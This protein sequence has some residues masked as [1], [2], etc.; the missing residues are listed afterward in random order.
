MSDRP[1]QFHADVDEEGLGLE[2]LPTSPGVYIFSDEHGEIIYIGKAANLRNRVRNYFHRSGDNRFSVQYIRTQCKRIDTILT[3]NE[4]EAFLLENTLIKKHRP[5]YNIRLRDDK[6]Y[7]SVAIDPTAEWPRA[8]VV[9]P[10]GDVRRGDKTLYFG[11]YDSSYS[12]RQMLKLLQKV[13]P[14]RSCSDTVFKNRSRPCLLHQIGRCVAPCVKPVDRK[15]YMELVRGTILSLRGQNDEA[16]KILEK[17]MLEHAERMEFEKA[18]AVRDRMQSIQASMEPQRVAERA[19]FNR[20]VIGYA[21]EQGHASIVVLQYRNGTLSDTHNYLLQAY[22]KESS[23]ILYGF[24][25]QFYG[26]SNVLPGEVFLNREPQDC[27]LIEEWLTELG[28]HKVRLH[29][30]KRGDKTE[31]TAMAERNA[32]ELLDKHLSGRRQAEENMESLQK[33]LQL[34]RLPRWI[35]C[36][37][38]STIQGVMSVGSLVSF[39]EGEADKA[40][41]RR[42]KIRSVEGQDDFAMMR[43]VLTRRLRGALEEDKPLPDLIIVDG[44]RG[45]L[46]VALAVFE[47]VRVTDLPVVGLAKSRLKDRGGNAK[48]RT[49]ERV[50]L[51]NRLNPVTFRSNAP[52]L[53][54]LQRI[55]DEAHRFGIEYH[56]KL[57][58]SKNTKSILEELPGIGPNRAKMILKEWKS[59]Q[60]LR[61]ASR[62][63]LEQ[64]ASIPK[65]LASTIWQFLHGQEDQRQPLEIEEMD[66][67]DAMS[68]PD[69][70]ESSVEEAIEPGIAQKIE[71]EEIDETEE[72]ITSVD[73]DEAP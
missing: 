43:E 52:A 19:H 33:A 61:E 22:D 25:T 44:G 29:Q 73:V 35:E 45:Q 27:E 63:E 64:S 34:P 39:R 32:R 72:N 2:H 65:N 49:E 15:E 41:Y 67:L 12:I 42:F 10:R 28:G 68:E 47:D 60:R 4:K 21:E 58:R 69:I 57:F 40:G 31:L 18:A 38:I 70:E 46:N 20:D 51:P 3:S 66:Y 53:F 30:P 6:T 7:V 56:R 17:R 13:F 62:E 24:L 59:L 26:E 16:L 71:Q 55:R 36:Y 54:L 23:E 8:V 50:F 5:R 11:P 14:I 48:Q 9:R 37:D 1:I